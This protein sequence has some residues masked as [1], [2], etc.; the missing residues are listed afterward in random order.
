MTKVATVERP[1][2]PPPSLDEVIAIILKDPDDRPAIVFGCV[3]D[4]IRKALAAAEQE[5]KA[6]QAAAYDPTVLDP[7]AIGRAHDAE[8]RIKRLTNAAE[9]LAPHHLA[10][11]KREVREQWEASIS[12][13]E[14]RVTNL[15]QELL[16]VYPE[17]VTRLVDM[18][19]R[20]AAVDKEVM[21]AN[22]S[23]PDGMRHL[24]SIEA[25]VT[26]GSSTKII[27]RVKLPTL[28]VDGRTVPDAWPLPAPS[29]GVAMHDQVLAMCRGAPP[30]PTEAERIAE[31][32]RHVAHGEAMERE[33][34]RL[35]DEAAA[36]A[37][38][39]EREQR[40][41]AAGG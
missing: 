28:T 37:T 17:L 29:I 38:Q 11:V 36:R 20:C 15:A 23:A 30:P 14:L 26:N 34:Q 39:H 18:F 21:Q 12:D 33:H 5:G 1:E 41:V 9:A 27:P 8:F 4:Q 25:T 40:R 10:A 3:L 7:T 16:S 31:S 24:R 6:A 32:A 2:A 13:L 35:N 19:S 22:S